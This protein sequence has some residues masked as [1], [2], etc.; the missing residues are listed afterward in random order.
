MGQFAHGDGGHGQLLQG[1]VF[2]PMPNGQRLP[3]G[4]VDADVGVQQVAR[5]FACETGCCGHGQKASR[6]WGGVS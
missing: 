3:F 2:K 5:G 1:V 4:D 6:S